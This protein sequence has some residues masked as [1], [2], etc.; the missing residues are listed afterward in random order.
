[1][2]HQAVFDLKLFEKFLNRI[3]HIKKPLISG[4]WPLVSIRNAEFM[5]NEVP[6]C[7]VPD[8]VM[9]RLRKVQDSKE[10]SLAE[11]IQI[12]RET[13]E[14]MLGSIQ[15]IQLSAPFGRVQS[16]IDVLSGFVFV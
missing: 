15:G 11:G 2:S 6:G 14:A 12:A 3:Q 1:M 8:F 9:E 7:N 13:L 5:N 16:V 4:L 10:A